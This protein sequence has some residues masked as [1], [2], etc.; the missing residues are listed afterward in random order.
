VSDA[1]SNY[2]CRYK[3]SS[4]KYANEEKV[5]PIHFMI[6][7][8]KTSGHRQPMGSRVLLADALSLQVST[9]RDSAFPIGSSEKLNT[10]A[11]VIEKSLKG[12][13]FAFDDESFSCCNATRSFSTGNCWREAG[14]Q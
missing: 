8:C 13:Q 2:G 9:H 6:T 4:G 12:R 5:V 11:A 10:L 14:Q 7:R 1:R 3:A